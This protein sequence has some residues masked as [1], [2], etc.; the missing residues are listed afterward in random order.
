MLY[1]C[2]SFIQNRYNIILIIIVLF[3]KLIGISG[4]IPMSQKIVFQWWNPP[5][6]YSFILT[7]NYIVCSLPY[8]VPSNCHLLY[9][10]FVSILAALFVFPAPIPSLQ[11]YIWK[12]S[13]LFS[14]SPTIFNSCNFSTVLFLFE[15]LYL[16]FSTLAELSRVFL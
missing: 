8:P 7:T 10:Y 16:K 9:P 11:Q 13:T 3:F 12:V 1:S 2:T 14:T 15:F 4:S 5:F 6:Q